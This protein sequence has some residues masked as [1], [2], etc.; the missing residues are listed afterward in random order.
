VRC[1]RH[2]GVTAIRLAGIALVG[3]SLVGG[4]CGN[5]KRDFREHE[6]NPSIERVAEQRTALAGLLRMSRPHLAADERRLRA[7][8]GQLAD[9]MRRVAR[10]RPPQGVE[11]KFRRYTRANTA[12]LAGLSRFV[13]ALAGESAERRRQAEERALSALARA[14]R[15]QT[16]LQ[17]ALR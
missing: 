5:A 11:V 14:S 12:L 2:D 15:A 17:H 13:D 16:E 8:L 4:G 6:L 3:F 9:A 7:Q 10:L 1:G